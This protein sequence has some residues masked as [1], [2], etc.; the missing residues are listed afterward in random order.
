[1]GR[2]PTHHENDM[3]L[4]NGMLIAGIKQ[5][6]DV[7]ALAH[8]MLEVH[9]REDADLA[10]ATTLARLGANVGL[11]A[12]TRPVSERS[13]TSDSGQTIDLP[14]SRPNRR[15]L[16]GY[17]GVDLGC[18]QFLDQFNP[19]GGQIFSLTTHNFVIR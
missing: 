1:M 9:W 8:C 14:C 12:V 10:D 11:P 17:Q 6:V 7:S 4:D 2:R 15:T 13:R 3:T 18:R 19:G 16:K 5:G